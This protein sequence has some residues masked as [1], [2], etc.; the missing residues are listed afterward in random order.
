MRI[1][2]QNYLVPTV[3]APADLVDQSAGDLS[4]SVAGEVV[5]LSSKLTWDLLLTP[6]KYEKHKRTKNAVITTSILPRT[7]LCTPQKT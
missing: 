2:S 7:C 6:E 1:L 3:E 4:A 5:A